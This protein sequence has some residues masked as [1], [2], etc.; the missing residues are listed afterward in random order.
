MASSSSSNQENQAFSAFSEIEPAG[1]RRKVSESS[2]LYDVFIN[3]RG[4][5]V[6]LTLAT[7]LYNSLEQLG[8]RAFLNS[9][10]KELEN[11][12]P[13]NVETA[14]R[15]AKVHIA[16]F[17]PRYAESPWCLAELLL[18]LES[19]AKI[20][21]VYYKVKPSDLRYIQSGHYHDAFFE[22]KEKGRY[23]DKLDAW[24][25]ALQSLSFTA[26]KEY[27]SAGD[28]E[29]IV[30][31]VQKE[32]QRKTCLHVA[33]HPVGLKNLVKD[34][35][36]RCLHERVQDFENQYGL[37]ERK[38][39][40]NII[41]I[42]GMSGLGKTTLAKELFNRMRS[43]YYGASFLSDVREQSMRNELP[44]LQ[45]RLLKD[46]F[47][48][49]LT[50]RSTEEGTSCIE[51]YLQRSPTLSFMIVLDDI[52]NVV[53]L[54]SLR[55]MDILKKSENSLVIVTTRDVGVLITA[56]ITV[57]Y[58]LK[59][60]DKND[61]RELFCWH[62]FSQAHPRSGYEVLVDDFIG[63]CGGLPLSLE[64]LGG[65]VRGRDQEYWRSMLIEV[66]ELLP[67][68][69]KQRLRIS[70]DALEDEEKQIF[71]DIA[72]FFVGKPKSIA[73]RV[74]EG[75]G[76][77]AQSTMQTLKE[78]CLVEEK[79][80]ENFNTYEGAV[81]RMHNHLRD[82]GREMAHEHS[83]PHRLW[84]PQDLKSLELM[85]HETILAKTN[86]RCFQSIF[87]ESMGSQVT[88][89]LAQS[90]SCVETSAFLLW[91]QLEGNSSELPSIPSWIP[92]R[93][94]QCLKIK[95]GRFNRLWE[96]HMQVPSQLKELQIS[97]TFLKEIPDLGMS[98]TLEKVLLDSRGLPIAGLPLLESLNMNLCSLCLR[99]STLKGEQ[100]STKR[101]QNILRESLVILNF[102]FN[103]MDWDNERPSCSAEGPMS[104]LEK[105]EISDEDCVSKILISEMNHPSLESIKLHDMKELVEVDLRMIETLSYVE[106]T[107]CKKLG[108]VLGI[109]NL[110]NLVEIEISGCGKL[111]FEYL[112]FSSMRCLERIKFDRNVM[113]KCFVL[114]D[115]QNLKTAQFCC[116]KLV[117]LSIRDC[118]EIV[119]IP[120]FVGPSC[121]KR[122]LIDRCGKL[123]YLQLN[124]CHNLKSVSGN[125]EIRR[126][127][128]SD[129]PELEELPDL[130]TLISLSLQRCKDLQIVAGICDHMELRG[131]IISDCP[132]LEEL[133]NLFRLSYLER[134]VIDSCENLHSISGIE[135]L[136]LPKY[137]KLCYCSNAVIRNCI[138][139]LKGVPSEVMYMLGKPVDGAESSLNECLFSDANIGVDGVIESG[140]CPNW[141]E[142]SFVI[143]CF[144]VVV[145]SHT[146]VEDINASLDPNYGLKVREGEWII[147]MVASANLTCYCCNYKEISN[148]L[149]RHGI[150]KKGFRLEVK[151]GEEGKSLSVLHT[152][153]D[154]LYL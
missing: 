71:M 136:H 51:D 10:E 65:Q 37:G 92:L 12:F 119:E 59:E 67:Q 106:I 122:I 80:I 28:C 151:K 16:I 36:R 42:F 94:L 116:Q 147:T 154:T 24:M 85:G 133:P 79:V 153:V 144:V 125:F 91:L 115:C 148:A 99:S 137:M 23:S 134:I 95:G 112:C 48:K 55:I 114:N 61:A 7:Q 86:V 96:D 146:S 41:G 70:F 139:K 54:S 128:I 15:S 60:M 76:W 56:G 38:H 150:M 104:G 93:K 20:I 121:L 1:K 9:Q 118:P 105:L 142:L 123:E 50:F 35:E 33:E 4:L 22:Y 152:I 25:K 135:D 47:D 100:V 46:L 103:E 3:H 111:E 131:L 68:D 141:L 17:S 27:N 2:T 88:F 31:V 138:H 78:K 58:N 108:S 82:L 45:S 52:D 110:V 75:S 6:K 21:P 43:N 13:S 102:Q 57:D 129:C 98:D 62:A 90:D 63:I 117:E 39:K 145:D 69:V 32:V 107:N 89:F 8:I 26:G 101:G 64:V 18:M 14:I 5:D 113:L 74:W 84:R 11:S 49:N 109:P 126:L 120:A 34:F 40:P 19:K 81:L 124:G 44:S 127:C 53:Q 77:D 73:E 83:P 140:A 72:C 132:E 149:R 66:K 130:A 30:E 97:E 143:G 87:D 29:K